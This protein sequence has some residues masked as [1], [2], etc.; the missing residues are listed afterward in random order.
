M[1]LSSSRNV[2]SKAVATQKVGTFTHHKKR[3]DRRILRNIPL[4]DH[5]MMRKFFDVANLV[6]YMNI[7]QSFCCAPFKLRVQFEFVN[8]CNLMIFGLV[9]F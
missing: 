4:V 1:L 5:P 6:E 2:G 3:F 9:V 7:A 8:N